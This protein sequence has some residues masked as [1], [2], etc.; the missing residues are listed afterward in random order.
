MIKVEFI[1]V[2]DGGSSKSGDNGVKSKGL[3]NKIEFIDMKDGWSSKS[4]D[5]GVK[6]KGMSVIKGDEY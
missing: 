3:V 5:N 1:G 2:R 4:G 6:N